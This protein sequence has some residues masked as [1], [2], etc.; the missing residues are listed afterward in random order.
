MGAYQIKTL[1][2]QIVF[3]KCYEALIVRTKDS[4]APLISSQ[5]I[6]R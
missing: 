4:P 2:N 5:I 3:V 6:E 1:I